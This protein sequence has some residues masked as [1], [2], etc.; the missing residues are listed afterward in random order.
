MNIDLIFLL[1]MND[2]KIV[3]FSSVRVIY[4]KK[5]NDNI[6]NRCNSKKIKGM[7]IL[8]MDLTMRPI[9]WRIINM[10]ET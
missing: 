3:V 2:K 6:D 4:N 9:Y 1:K 7:M 8:Q 10:I 5:N